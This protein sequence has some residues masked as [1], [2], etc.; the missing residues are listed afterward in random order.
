[1]DNEN[2]NEN[3]DVILKGGAG[4]KMERP[5]ISEV[6]K[7]YL[8]KCLDKGIRPDMS[9]GESFVN[10]YESKGWMIGKNK[11]KSWKNAV[12]TWINKH[13]KTKSNNKRVASDETSNT[14]DIIADEINQTQR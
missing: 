9:F 4:G 12:S 3:K 10:F 2:E 7:H 14:V 13:E 6:Q 11:M 1:M 5:S 8:Q